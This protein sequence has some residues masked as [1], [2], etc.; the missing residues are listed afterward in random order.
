LLLGSG[1]VFASAVTYAIYLI[2]GAKLVLKMGSL[3]FAAYAATAASVFSITHFLFVKG[4]AGL[5]VPQPVYWL[6]LGM[7]TLSTVIPLWLL[8]EGLRRIGANQAAMVGCIGPVT[9]IL[10]AWVF[11]GEPITLLQSA[12]AAL[13]LAGV[14]VISIKP[15]ANSG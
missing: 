14:M 5:V 6:M 2:A 11:L 9:T 4:T 1:L 15:Q 10:F 13:V 7:A 12:G 8:A 3:R